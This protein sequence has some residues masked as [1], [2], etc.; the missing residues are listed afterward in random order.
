MYSHHADLPPTSH[1]STNQ[2]YRA[3]TVTL[4]RAPNRDFS[5]QTRTRAYPGRNC[6]IAGRENRDRVIIDNCGGGLNVQTNYHSTDASV[7]PRVQ[8]SGNT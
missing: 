1:H 2:Y 8:V 3:S 5:I 7:H 6:A 4:Y